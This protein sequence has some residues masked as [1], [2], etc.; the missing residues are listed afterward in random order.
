MH[1]VCQLATSTHTT[2]AVQGPIV[3]DASKE[4]EKNC[5]RSG[6]LPKEVQ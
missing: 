2:D 5:I 3:R 4:P 1:G 6:K